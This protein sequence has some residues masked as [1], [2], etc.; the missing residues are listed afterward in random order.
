MPII[1]G[2]LRQRGQAS[3]TDLNRRHSFLVPGPPGAGVA[4][5]RAGRLSE[6]LP[7]RDAGASDSLELTPQSSAPA[8]AFSSPEKTVP[9]DR[10]VS[11]PV[12]DAS[13]K[14][15]RRFSMMKFRHAS[16]SQLSTRA[17]Q[18]AEAEADAAPPMPR[19]P[20]IITTAP[21]LEV[22]TAQK[23]KSKLKLPGIKPSD[24]KPSAFDELIKA[25]KKERRKTLSEGNSSSRVTFDEPVRHSAQVPGPMPPPYGDDTGS[26][27]ALP[28]NR[29]SESSRSDG[30]S[31]DNHVYAQT[32]TTI[33]TT[34][35]TTTFFRLPRRKKPQPL[36][37]LPPKVVH[38]DLPNS[39]SVPDKSGNNTSRGSTDSSAA[40][41]LRLP[42]GADDN[43]GAVHTHSAI[44][45]A[46]MLF[47]AP[48]SP[49]IRRDSTASTK[50]SPTRG[51][52]R[53]RSSTLT[54]LRNGQVDEPLDTPPL[55]SSRTSTS[56]GRKS[57]GDIFNL[58]HRLRPDPMP[59]ASGQASPLSAT[60]KNNSIQITREPIIIPE[61]HQDDS[62]A[63]YL[64]RL[65]EAVSRGAVA[66]V[67]SKGSDTFSQQVLRSYMRGFGFFGDPMDM[68][69][70]KLLMEV[71]LPK[72][73]QHIDRCLQSFAHRYHEC[74][75]GIYASPE[76]AYFIAFSLLILHTD[77]F[78][79]NNK[80]KMQKQDYCKN[81]QGE[82]IFDE[83]LECF[84]DNIS[85]TPF[86]HVED[87]LDINGERIVQ[88]KSK[89]KSLFPR[90]SMD[91]MKRP[92]K[93]PVDPYTLII[94]SKLDS[95]RPNLKDVMNLE[96]HYN[97][98]GTALSLNLD[99]LQRTFFRTGVLQ[100]I[101]ARSRPDAFMSDKTV[102]NPEEAHPGIVDIKI[103]KVGL[104]WR[105]D[106]KKKKTRS[107]WQEWGAILTGAQLYF[108]RNTAWIKS[109]IHQHDHHV[110]QGN[111]GIPVTFKPPIDSFKPDALM[112]TDDAVALLDSTYKKHKNAFLFVRHGG[113]EETFLA[114]NEDE[115]NDWLAK[116]NYAAAF[117]TAGVRMR[118]V[119]G[120]NYEGQRTRGIRRLDSA[121]S[122]RSVQTPTGE[123]QIISGK[124]DLQMAQ[125]ILAARREIMMQKIT[126][127]EEK[128][129]V[130]TKQLDAQLR[131]A[132]HLM[133]LAPILPKTREQ[134]VLAA[135]RMSAK[136]RWVRM[137]IWRL[138]CHRDILSM[139]LDEEVKHVEGEK[140]D[141]VLPTA[142]LSGDSLAK[143]NDRDSI[144][145]VSSR[146]SAAL[147]PQQS[148]PSQHPTPI[149]QASPSDF[150]IDDF[151]TSPSAAQSASTFHK[152]QASW[153]LPPL[154][155]DGPRKQL[156]PGVGAQ[157]RSPVLSHTSSYPRMT[158]TASADPQRSASSP[159]EDAGENMALEQAGLIDSTI[160][161]DSIAEEPPT[162]A[163]DEPPTTRPSE[164]TEKEKLERGKIRRS[165]HR[166]LRDAHVPTQHRSRKGKDSSS[167]AKEGEEVVRDDQ[168]ARGTGSFVIHGKKASVITFGDALANMSAEERMRLK[169]AAQAQERGGSVERDMSVR[170]SNRDAHRDAHRG[171]EA[172]TNTVAARSFRELHNRLS[173]HAA[174]LESGEGGAASDSD[175]AVSVLSEE[176]EGVVRTPLPVVEDVD[177]EK[178]Q[179]AAFYTPEVPGTP[180]KTDTPAKMGTPGKGKGRE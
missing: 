107:P 72:E 152:A 174:T 155:F 32:T 22:N 67:L 95:L 62:P 177:E 164:A 148:S 169:K 68:A 55:P 54:S 125:D 8:I 85:Y 66:S 74:N 73:T 161:S 96:E 157:P 168:L 35:T 21:T 149:P 65:E 40:Q 140:V 180:A 42:Q 51:G 5:T 24:P 123:V 122:G 113:F 141:P 77:V 116:L 36:F 53:G 37:P 38:H 172:S 83:I 104:L 173:A 97:Y 91:P 111:D 166:T 19:P 159:Q 79:K 10:P 105:K 131:N 44:A 20:E 15:T 163:S 109:L 27:L 69:L 7:R 100:I 52:L 26:T 31:A 6:Q 76:Q 87:D 58:T 80:N 124:I 120:G 49:L 57:F 86:I 34:H 39:L 108:F 25:S 127:A 135:G 103:T 98:I 28:V 112:S 146:N 117:R 128:L 64:L 133:I 11:P 136:L 129:A 154:K 60:S 33:Q 47:A 171:S 17:R 99:D 153:E 43:E 41:T 151:F 178:W 158:P 90:S 130:A 9:E 29:L 94:D 137:E 88:H 92:S 110:K 2:L 3:E 93:E 61:R 179:Q 143:Q 170:D 56:T 114:D 119:V 14:Q 4:D 59:H 165:I 50:S 144:A 101:S 84:Y 23:K 132:R 150:D 175:A 46:S 63:K 75:P 89:K 167:S 16:D 142:N 13:P 160:A 118:G 30:S 147:S 78:N 12:Q 1:P 176:E 70:R 145:G 81:T 71:E 102:M 45:K 138:R 106:P 48:G 162:T 115:M 82:G 134:V 139:D 121:N 18:Q 156:S 126:E